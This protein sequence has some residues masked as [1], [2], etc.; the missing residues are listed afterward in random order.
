MDYNT[1]RKKLIL[2]EYGRNI[3]KMV[4]FILTVEDRNERNRLAHS[5]INIMGNMN[6]QLR[7]IND[8]KH[9]LWDHLALMAE[10]KLDIDYPYELPNSETLNKAPNK[11]PYQDKN[12]K[13]RHYGVTVQRFIEEAKKIEDPEEKEALAVLIAEHMK[14]SYY[15]WNKYVVTDDV[16]IGDLSAMSG[17]NLKLDVDKITLAEIRETSARSKVVKKKKVVRKK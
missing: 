11:V 2:P 9:K 15:N 1:S 17:G 3:H 13:Y 14:K 4:D 10:F 7:D 12:R 6:P 5:V 8:F 16:I